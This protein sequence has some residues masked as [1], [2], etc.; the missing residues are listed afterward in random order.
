MSAQSSC[1]H[2]SDISIWQSQPS[3]GNNFSLFTGHM[4]FQILGLP[5]CKNLWY[6]LF[7]SL[8]RAGFWLLFNGFLAL[9]FSLFYVIREFDR[10]LHRGWAQIFLLVG[11]F[12]NCTGQN[13]WTGNTLKKITQD[14]LVRCSVIVSDHNAKLAGHFR[15]LV[16]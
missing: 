3:A 2:C 16:G 14:E 4:S 10:F 11:H 6:I 1:N 7:V 8:A 9:L 13:L 12:T 5:R 15:N